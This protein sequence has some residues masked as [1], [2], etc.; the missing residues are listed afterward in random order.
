MESYK[1]LLK[2][3]VTKDLRKLP[4]EDVKRLLARIRALASVPRPPGCQKLSAQ[5]WYRIRAGRYRF[6]YEIRDAELVVLVVKVADRKE[7]Y[8]H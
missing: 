7:V 6:V 2:R 4:T 5:E 3:S 8:R 1:L